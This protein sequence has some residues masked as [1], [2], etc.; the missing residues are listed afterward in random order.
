MAQLIPVDNDPFQG[1]AK[2]YSLV[3]V[4]HDPFASARSQVDIEN[5]MVPRPDIQ[6][7]TVPPRFGDAL[8]PV[9]GGHNP[10]AEISD[11]V[12]PS[13]TPE[14]QAFRDARGVGERVKD[15]AAFAAG[16]PVRL[17]SGG[18]YGV[19]D[20]LSYFGFPEAAM[21]VGQSEADFARANDPMLR[22][23]GAIGEV[24]AAYP[25]GFVHGATHPISSTRAVPSPAPQTGRIAGQAVS[26]ARDLEAFNR[27]SVRPF[28][29]AFS[30]GPLAAAA[31]QLSEVP[32]LGAPVRNA[33]EDS[34]TGLRDRVSSVADEIASA[35]TYERAGAR[36]QSGLDRFR[37]AGVRDLEPG[38]L[39]EIEA[40]SSRSVPYQS[41]MS[42]GAMTA[43]NDAQTIRAANPGLNITE[44]ATGVQVPAARPLSQTLTTRTD[45]TDLTNDAIFRLINTPAAETSFAARQEALYERAFRMVPDM[46]RINGTRNPNMIAAVN[47]RSALREIDQNIAN[48]VSGSSGRI[49]GDL[50]DRIRNAQSGNFGLDQLRAMRTEIGRAL[51]QGNPL[52][53][54]L[55]RSH[56]KRLYSAMSQDI[57]RGL[58][59]LANRAVV[60]TQSGGNAGDRVAIEDARMATGALRAFREA[61][62]YT[63]LGMRNI[64]RFYKTLNVE[65]PEA[66]AK[67]LV[68]SALDG[69]KGDIRRFR[70]AMAAL[71][72]EE[73]NTFSSLMLRELGRP[74][75]SAR[76]L[77]EDIEFSP[78][79]FVTRWRS[80]SPEARNLLFAGEHQRAINDLV[81]IADRMANVEALANSSR[82]TTNAIGLG[83]VMTGIGSY[84]AGGLEGLLGYAGSGAALSVLMSR[85]SY[86]KWA[87]AYART[88]AQA[89][90]GPRSA[91]TAIV[92]Q[93]RKLQRMAETDPQ[94]AAIA[95]GA[96]ADNGIREDQKAEQIKQFSK[97]MYLGGP[98]PD[99]SNSDDPL[100]IPGTS[101]S[102]DFWKDQTDKMEMQRRND[103]ILSHGDTVLIP[104][105]SEIGSK[106]FAGISNA[107]DAMLAFGPM[108]EALSGPM[109]YLSAATQAF[110]NGGRAAVAAAGAG[111]RALSKPTPEQTLMR[112]RTEN[113]ALVKEG[114]A[115]G[116]RP[117]DMP[118]IALTPEEEINMLSAVNDAMSGRIK[119][120]RGR[121]DRTN[122]M[123]PKSS[124]PSVD[125]YTPMAE[126][127]DVTDWLARNPYTQAIKGRQG[128]PSKNEQQRLTNKFFD[129]GGRLPAPGPWGRDLRA[130]VQ[131]AIENAN[132]TEGRTGRVANRP[133]VGEVMQA[134]RGARDE[135][136]ALAKQ[137]ADLKN[138]ATPQAVEALTV[139][140]SEVTQELEILRAAHVAARRRVD[141][142]SRLIEENKDP[143]LPPPEASQSK[144]PRIY[145][146][147]AE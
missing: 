50:A 140:L 48:D 14:D 43:A 145:K 74:V 80:L 20:T 31:K 127:A 110:R 134:W 52:Q 56:L 116:V 34:I 53:Q 63:R 3:P 141:G 96:A 73:R 100:W 62:R 7:Q 40:P 137:L 109:N 102:E 42:R 79:S 76:G 45:A 125:G 46:N 51:S 23:M 18:K 121:L 64:E 143:G 47:T 9:F 39:D 66:A 11:L 75:A 49:S 65:N 97:P 113:D 126:R 84:G 93:V 103:A 8:K 33:L 12:W 112:L 41:Q 36:I 72:P 98:K 38:I 139:R 58:E 101:Q 106:I 70:S 17:L 77:V 44:T 61:D 90:R 78:Q 135:A 147:G 24:S 133:S 131:Y 87:V 28:G 35:A 5:A 117:G 1:P 99:P 88:R 115:L 120:V 27:Q 130:A 86:A 81:R 19:S 71:R 4:E 114:N 67:S 26:A 119:A 128:F 91:R 57:E 107:G 105:L 144:P 83:S 68:R 30:Q 142:L 55:N 123:A 89:L 59:T 122:A 138:D 104:G 6:V 108:G 13:I 124:V 95:A 146:R 129:R 85:P 54:T 10:V 22:T 94:L 136:A 69:D 132:R 25:A 2:G 60:R 92:G 32:F 37:S 118:D 21:S 111:E 29:P 15:T 82:S 16:V